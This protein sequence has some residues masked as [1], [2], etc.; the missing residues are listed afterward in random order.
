[1][2]RRRQE[3][4]GGGGLAVVILAIYLDRVSA[5]LGGQG[6]G[7]PSWW[8]KRRP[9]AGAEIADQDAVLEKELVGA[10]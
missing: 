2:P 10:P 3:V 4:G 9:Q 5:A 6:R 7:N 1:V 8:P